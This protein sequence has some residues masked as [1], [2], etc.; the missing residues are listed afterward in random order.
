MCFISYDTAHSDS[1]AAVK[2]MVSPR[3]QHSRSH[4]A[5][6]NKRMVSPTPLSTSVRP[7][8][9]ALSYATKHIHALNCTAMKLHRAHGRDLRGPNKG[10]KGSYCACILSR[11]SSEAGTSK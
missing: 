11:R 3:P 6:V 9:R 1:L 4:S 8:P 10:F 5:T 2:R 7:C